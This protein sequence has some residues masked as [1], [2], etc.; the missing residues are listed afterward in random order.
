LENDAKKARFWRVLASNPG[1]LSIVELGWIKR[2]GFAGAKEGFAAE[3]LWKAVL[4][5]EG[6]FVEL[7]FCIIL[8]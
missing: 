7:E 2:G 4:E 5:G 6:H 3:A 8:L 1:D